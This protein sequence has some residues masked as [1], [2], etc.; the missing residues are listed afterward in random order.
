MEM[1]TIDRGKVK[2][3]ATVGTVLAWDGWMDGWARSGKRPT[4]AYHK[5]IGR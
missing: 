1:K 3:A 2:A 5:K 4:L